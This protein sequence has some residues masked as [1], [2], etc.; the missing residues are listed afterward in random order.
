MDHGSV[1]KRC[2]CRD[3]ESSRLL[4][5]RCPK[6]RSPRHGSWYFSADLPPAAGKLRH[7]GVAGSAELSCAVGCGRVS[8]TIP[9]GVG[10]CTCRQGG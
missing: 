2:G 5:T 3:Q 1:F 4:G 9:S 7:F 8:D 6:L 10:G